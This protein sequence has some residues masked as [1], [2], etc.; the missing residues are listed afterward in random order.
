M[1]SGSVVIVADEE[2]KKKENEGENPKKS[3]QSQPHTSTKRNKQK[4]KKKGTTTEENE[5]VKEEKKENEEE[6]FADEVLNLNMTSSSLLPVPD[7]LLNIALKKQNLSLKLNKNRNVNLSSA[8]LLMTISDFTNVRVILKFTQNITCVINDSVISVENNLDTEN[9]NEESDLSEYSDHSEIFDESEY[10]ESVLPVCSV[11]EE[12]KKKRRVYPTRERRGPLMLQNHSKETTPNYQYVLKDQYFAQIDSIFHA[13]LKVCTLFYHRSVES[14]GDN[15]KHKDE[16]ILNLLPQAKT[17]IED[18]TDVFEIG[19]SRIFEVKEIF[20]LLGC[21]NLRL[22][23]VNVK[24]VNK[25]FMVKLKFYPNMSEEQ[26]SFLLRIQD[27]LSHIGIHTNLN[28]LK[29]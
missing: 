2:E 19:F 17:T 13:Y 29:K 14:Q 18:C 1:N 9:D 26:I 10:P 3:K 25:D 28:S 15:W 6:S 20:L 5:E 27:N 23:N 8:K 16:P 24:S 11:K 22:A 21:L 12:E 4:K 7:V